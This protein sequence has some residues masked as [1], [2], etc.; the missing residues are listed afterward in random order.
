MLAAHAR[1]ADRGAGQRARPDLDRHAADRRPRRRRARARRRLRVLQGRHQERPVG[2]HRRH[3]RALVARHVVLE[4]TGIAEPAA[5]LDGLVRVPD[6]VRD[7]ILPAGVICVVDAET[8]ARGAATT[9][10]EAREQA[11]SR[12]SRAAREARRRRRADAVRAT[13][14][15]ARRARARTP[16]APRFPADDAGARAMTA[17]IVEPR[18]LRAWTRADATART[19][20]RSRP[21]TATTTPT[22][23]SR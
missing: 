11:L 8:G 5:I 10:D 7:R 18:K 1:Q 19:T 20:T 15:A 14:R 22:S 6:A 3:R 13:P 21:R 23:S 4:T 16:S 2:R 12:R 17:W 9:R